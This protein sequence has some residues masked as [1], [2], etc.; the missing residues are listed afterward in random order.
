LAKNPYELL[1]GLF[2]VS[3]AQ[4]RHS[5]TIPAIKVTNGQRFYAQTLCGSI[6][7]FE[8]DRPNIVA[9]ACRS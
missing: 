6:T 2:Y 9:M 7:A 5:Q 1:A 3:A 8:I 4:Q